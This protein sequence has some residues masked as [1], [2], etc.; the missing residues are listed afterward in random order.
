[1]SAALAQQQQALLQALWQAGH[2]EAIDAMSRAQLTAGRPGPQLWQRG[3]RAYR[4]NGHEL[5]QRSL[6]AAYPVVAQLLGD[7]NFQPL[8]RQLW[9]GHPPVRGD[10]AQWGDALPAHIESLP[11]LS[12]QEPYLADVARVEWLL[13]AVAY[14]ADASQDAASFAL[15]ADE[16]PASFTLLLAP[17][18]AWVSSRYPVV[19]IIRAHLE[20]EPSLE[21]S[22]RR[23]RAG[24]HETALVWRQGFQPRLREAAAGEAQFVAALRARRSLASALEAAPEL[25]FEAWLS[26][27]VE[28]G[29]L[30]GAALLSPV[31]RKKTT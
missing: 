13:H 26:P 12:E 10:L 31:F 24:L 8:A 28:R 18:T 21:E 15:L 23:L 19:S 22:G 1:M 6:A 25:D 11:G 2:Q 16:D 7:E 9:H 30:L 14:A 20:S 3:L 29:L 17:G 27:A 5:A 4:S